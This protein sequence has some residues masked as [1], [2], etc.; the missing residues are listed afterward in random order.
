MVQPRMRVIIA[1]GSIAGLSLALM[2]ENHGIDFLVLEAYPEIAPQVGASIAILPNG[3]RILDQLGCYEDIMEQAQ[4]PVREVHFRR[5]TG[6]SF[7][8]FLDFSQNSIRRHGY[9]VVF[10]DR[11]MVIATL[12]NH[13]KDKS[14]VLTRKRVVSVEQIED[15]VKVRTGDD[16]IYFGDILVGADGNKSIVR[17][18]MWEIA[19]QIDAKWID[20]AE[21]TVFNLGKT[22]Y[23]P[24]IPNF[25]KEDEDLIAKEHWKD[26]ITEDLQFSDIYKR[27]VSSVCTPLHE[28]VYKHWYFGRIMTIGD[29]CHKFE[30]L[31]GQGGNSAIETAASFTNYL[32]TKLRSAKQ[33]YLSDQDVTDVFESVQRIRRPRVSK[34]VAESHKRQQLEAMETPLLEAV[35]TYLVPWIGKS[36]V[37]NRWI[38]SYCPAVSLEHLPI[39]ERMHQIPYDDQLH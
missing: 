25:T 9:P 27:K 21:S 33:D 35:A 2:L 10:L 39:P 17:Q 15:G 8:S 29:S 16:S 3:M 31:T 1:G 37:F 13:I 28:H 12:H 36:A 24:E 18:Q 32:V 38:Q 6:Q 5:S 14:K 4:V 34:L 30:P 22:F 7:W 19:K 20:P 23:G 26:Q 11:R